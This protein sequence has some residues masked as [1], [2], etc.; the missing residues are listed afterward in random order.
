MDFHYKLRLEQ[1]VLGKGDIGALFG[2]FYFYVHL[3]SLLA[4]LF[5]T[6]N[7]IRTIGLSVCLLLLP[8]IFGA[9]ALIAFVLPGYLLGMVASGIGQASKN[10]LFEPAKE[11]L[12]VPCTTD[13]K[14]K[15]KAAIDMFG[16]RGG[17]GVASILNLMLHS[18]FS[19]F[20]ESLAYA[21]I[22]CAL[23]GF[24]IFASLLAG[25]GFTKRVAEVSAAGSLR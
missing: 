12:Y 4:L 25:R 24:W 6:K 23:L 11:L 18:T 9:P 10:G 17:K 14:Y 20:A 16:H 7:I 21:V 15:A 22:F 13:E 3:G 1:V 5:A 8:L 19:L 2:N